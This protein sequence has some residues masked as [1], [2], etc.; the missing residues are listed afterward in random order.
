[1]GEE[2]GNKRAAG[3]AFDKLR[4]TGQQAENHFR[5]NRVGNVAG[6]NLRQQKRTVGHGHPFGGHLMFVGMKTIQPMGMARVPGAARLQ[7]FPCQ[8]FEKL[9][10]AGSQYF[11]GKTGGGRTGFQSLPAKRKIGREPFAPRR[12]EGE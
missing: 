1:M 4:R 10:Q 3:R 5:Q 9:I 6:R 12:P 11:F 7:D 8:L 2:P